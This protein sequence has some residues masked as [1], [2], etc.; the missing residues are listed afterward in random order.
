M[1]VLVS[2]SISER[3][4]QILQEG[5]V[6]VVVKTG[7]NQEELISIIGEFDGLVVR[8][9]QV[10]SDIIKQRRILSHWRTA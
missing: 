8:V 3:G 6:E 4:I 1:R 2:D 10:T 9:R 7:L 5:G